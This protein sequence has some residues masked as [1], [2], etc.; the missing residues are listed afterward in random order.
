MDDP[1]HVGDVNVYIVDTLHDLLVRVSYFYGMG[2][3]DKVSLSLSVGVEAT[4]LYN[5]EVT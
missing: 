2:L 1:S 4:E 3:N 5:N